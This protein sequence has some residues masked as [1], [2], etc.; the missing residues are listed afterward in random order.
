M[1]LTCRTEPAILKDTPASGWDAQDW[2]VEEVL[3]RAK[4]GV[5]PVVEVAAEGGGAVYTAFRPSSPLDS[6]G[7]GPHTLQQRRNVTVS[8]LAHALK[9]P[10][11]SPRLYFSGGTEHT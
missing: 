7:L 3:A 8:A 5:L 2:T 6:L 9:S 10:S 11:H 1:A 4:R